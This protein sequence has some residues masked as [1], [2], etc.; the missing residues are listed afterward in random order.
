MGGAPTR[1]QC[2]G[3][4]SITCTTSLPVWPPMPQL[5]AGPPTGGPPPVLSSL[6]ASSLPSS[7]PEAPVGSEPEPVPD[8]P[9]PPD[10]FPSSS[11]GESLLSSPVSPSSAAPSL[12]VSVSHAIAPELSS[13]QPA[14]NRAHAHNQGVTRG[15]RDMD[16]RYREP[17]RRARAD[18]VSVT[19][20]SSGAWRTHDA[21][22]MVDC[23]PPTAA[24]DALSDDRRNVVF[25]LR[26]HD[27]GDMRARR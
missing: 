12:S 17:L 6:A 27:G 8:V 23:A 21:C 14:Q 20:G 1:Y 7:V 22:A 4:S 2:A 24:A 19:T 16:P 3:F 11:A 13:P 10:G 18:L 9:P 26:S 15:G 5:P 25:Q